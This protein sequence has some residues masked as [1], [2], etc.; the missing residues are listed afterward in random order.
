M[1]FSITPKESTPNSVCFFCGFQKS[2]IYE[3]YT[4]L[5]LNNYLYLFY[6]NETLLSIFVT[7]KKITDKH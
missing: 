4:H 6:R 5:I 1:S 7:L 3:I 2:E